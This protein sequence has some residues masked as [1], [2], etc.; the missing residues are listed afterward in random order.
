MKP[1]PM[2]HVVQWRAEMVTQWHELILLIRKSLDPAP[3]PAHTR[4]TLN[5]EKSLFA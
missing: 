5:H 3:Q 2:A 1:F 4:T